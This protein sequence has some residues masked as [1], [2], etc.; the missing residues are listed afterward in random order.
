MCTRVNRRVAWVAA[1][2]AMS[3]LIASSALSDNETYADT[4]SDEET[5]QD[6]NNW[7]PAIAVVGAFHGQNQKSA[8]SSTCDIGG[9]GG[10]NGGLIACT[11]SGPLGR[12]GV[13]TAAATPS[14]LRASADGKE[15]GFWPGVGIDFHLMS[16]RIVELPFDVG[17]RAFFNA[18][19]TAV[20]PPSRATANEGS[21]QGLSFPESIPPIDYP[22]SAIGGE[23][24]ETTSKPDT[25]EFGAQVG[26]AFPIDVLKRKV[27]IKPSFGWLHYKVDV[28]GRLLS[29]IKDDVN[30]DPPSNTN[31]SGSYGENFRIIELSQSKSRNINAIGP[32]IEVELESGHFGP[33]GAAVFASAHGYKVLG[34][35][36]FKLK[37]SQ[38]FA[39][40]TGPGGDG[41]LADTYRAEWEHE[42]SP[43]VYRFRMGLRFHYVGEQ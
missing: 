20:F 14:E 42:I 12:N 34:N 7:V 6:V 36:K 22:A 32:G 11:Q 3:S 35:R 15:F 23:G 8:V 29:A 21:L 31:L 41:L 24:S 10:E 37:S 30:G 18:E 5:R 13:P 27:R 26:L 28:Q 16:P 19:I 40:G 1:L 4:Y 2:I 17:P 33:I 9:V 38:A 39:D 25:F 43:W